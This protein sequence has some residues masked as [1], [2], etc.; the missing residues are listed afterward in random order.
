[1]C[2]CRQPTNRRTAQQ[3]QLI[4]AETR[5]CHSLSIESENGNQMKTCKP[6]QMNSMFD[7]HR[8]REKNEHDRPKR[9]TNNCK[10]DQQLAMA[11]AVAYEGTTLNNINITPLWRRPFVINVLVICWRE[12]IVDIRR[13]RRLSSMKKEHWSRQSHSHKT[14]FVSESRVEF[15]R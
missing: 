15:G 4:D 12:A 8:K 6:N 11:M 1:M 7:R 9:E 2:V 5:N 10:C 14:T 13:H 3:V